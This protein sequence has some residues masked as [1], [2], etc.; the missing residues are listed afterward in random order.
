MSPIPLARLLLG[1]AADRFAGHVKMAL[2]LSMG[3]RSP[4]GPMGSPGKEGK[5]SA[6]DLT[7]KRRSAGLVAET[8]VESGGHMES[9]GVWT[10]S[11]VQSV[12]EPMSHRIQAAGEPEVFGL[13]RPFGLRRELVLITDSP[14]KVVS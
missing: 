1:F 8:P 4:V 9:D 6:R 11:R 10:T 5:G 12:D 3:A 2:Q 13:Q 14:D 7:S